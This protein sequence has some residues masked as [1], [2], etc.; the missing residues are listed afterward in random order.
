MAH[1]LHQGNTEL[2]VSTTLAG[3]DANLIHG[4]PLL[5]VFVIYYGLPSIGIEFAPAT[6]GTLALS[7]NA[8]TYLSKSIRG[9]IFG[10]GKRQLAA[11]YGL[12]LSYAQT[13]RH[14]VMPQALHIALP[15][16]SNTLISLIKNVSLVSVI[17][18]TEL[19]FAT[20]EV[21]AT[22]FRRLPLHLAAALVYWCL[23]LCF[24]VLQRRMARSLEQAHH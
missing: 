21:I 13:L 3:I 1:A 11:S 5:Q 12:G 2:A 6:S 22:T 16:M 14:I 7:L 4:T 15:S 9:V 10:V 17:T 24:E 18:V 19:M 23:S 20:K 8:G